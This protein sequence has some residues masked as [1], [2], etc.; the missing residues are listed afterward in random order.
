MNISDS[1]RSAN[2]WLKFDLHIHSLYSR[3]SLLS[4]ATIIKIAK[5]QGLNGVAVTDHGTIAGGV[6]TNKANGDAGFQVIIGAEIETEFGDILGLFLHR[7]IVSRSFID[8]CREIKE[9]HGLV[10]LAHPFRKGQILPEQLYGHIDFIEGFNAR[11]PHR[12]NLKA[13]ATAKKWG[14]PMIAGSDAHLSFEIGRGRTRL[15]GGIEALFH[16]EKM[17]P[18]IEGRESNYYM[19]HGLSLLT[20]GINK[21]QAFRSPDKE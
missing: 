13:Q 3:D 9:Q 2:S 15:N 16:P 12:L 10:A 18:S 20:Q 14:V 4:P 21:L 19:V 7:Q 17:G 6:A 1:S 11:S 8:V 5:K